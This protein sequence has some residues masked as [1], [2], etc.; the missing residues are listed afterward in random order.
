[1]TWTH[2]TGRLA[3]EWEDS[4]IRVHLREINCE[5]GINVGAQT[6]SW[7]EYQPDIITLIGSSSAGFRLDVTGSILSI[8]S[9]VYDPGKQTKTRKGI[10]TVRGD[11]QI[12]TLTSISSFSTRLFIT[13]AKLWN[14]GTGMAWGL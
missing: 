7:A 13:K 8:K 4:T 14:Y 11:V 1:M 9:S 12:L 2:P 5:D 3:K 10:V 6:A